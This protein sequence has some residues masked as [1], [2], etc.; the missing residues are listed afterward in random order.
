MGY[1]ES[2]N[3][4]H[5]PGPDESWQES[6]CYWFFDNKARV[7]GYHRIGQT[8]NKNG[9]AGQVMSFFF[10]EGGQRFRHVVEYPSD[11][12]VRGEADQKVGSHT[13]ESLG[14]DRIRYTFSETDCAADLEFYEQFY[15]PRNWMKEDD[16]HA[17]AIEEG[18]NT[19]GHLEV[20]GKV[21]GRVRI[22]D[23]EYDIDAFA[24][25]DRSWGNRD[26]S[27]ARQGRQITGTIG[28]SLSWTAVVGQLAENGFVFKVGFVARDGETTD[29]EDIK[30]LASID[31]DGF[32]VGAMKTRLVLTDGTHVDL[33]GPAIQGFMTIWQSPADSLVVSQNIVE[34]EHGG[35]KGMSNFDC[36]FRPR[37][38]TYIPTKDDISLSCLENGL[39]DAA[40]YSELA[41]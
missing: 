17:A 11:E 36:T 10:K 31:Y 13:V 32:T 23:Q 34:A 39:H 41:W 28:K 14:D 26:W 21:K 9:G 37:K 24:Q 40:D 38:G 35:A 5:P 7:G 6:D 33:A 1:D 30:V 18:F 20:A 29:I 8:P 12:C 15:T 4:P 19:D 3:R 27:T 2:W 22:G 25:R 16:E